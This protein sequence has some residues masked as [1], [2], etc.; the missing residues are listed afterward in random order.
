VHVLVTA[1]TVGG[2]WTYTRELVCGLL[3]HGHHVTLVSFGRMP[4]SAQ[5]FW[6][7]SKNLD[8]HPTEFPLE[9]MQDAQAGVCE[10]ARYLEKIIY[11][12]QPDVL[13]FNQFCYGALECGIPKVVVA[14]SD[15][16]SWWKA[17]HEDQPP[18]SPWLDWYLTLVSR[19]LHC[20][21]TV[22]APSQWM[23]D[24]VSEYYGPLSCGTVIY[25]GRS[26]T[27]FRPARQ[28]TDCVLS[29]G[30]VWDKAKQISLL[31]ARNH[32]VPIRIAGPTK[33]PEESCQN[34][35]LLNCCGGLE[36]CGEQSETQLCSLYSHAS[37]YAATSRYEPFGLAPLEAALSRCA[38]VAND[39][40][41]FRELWGDSAFYFRRNDPDSLAT[42]ICILS[43]DSQL[44]NDYAEQAYE[45]ARNRFD[46]Q[47]MVNQYEALYLDLTGGRA[48]A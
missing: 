43:A 33:H 10:S 46:S 14:H 30:R 41:V 13:H 7:T 2:V 12:A 6:I 45:C 11:E 31:L 25:N 5:T 48:S 32:S 37:T 24:A 9:W 44:R 40:P 4:T 27:L 29:V 38:L 22:V 23:L 17:V 36:L 21:D 3:N 42:A 15:V 20:A 1:D 19:G 35:T 28:K 47:R 39:I 26:S 34:S 16:V 8:Y 18:S